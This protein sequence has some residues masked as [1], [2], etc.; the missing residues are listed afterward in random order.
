MNVAGIIWIMAATV[1]AGAF[2][3][4][5]LVSPGIGA[6]LHL[7][8]WQAISVAAVLGAVLAVPVSQKVARAIA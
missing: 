7:N 1:L 6:A 8:S 3:L 4:A 2:V 5:V